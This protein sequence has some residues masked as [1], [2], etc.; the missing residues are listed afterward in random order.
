M[1]VCLPAENEGESDGVDP[2]Q[3]TMEQVTLG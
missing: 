3:V 2:G 1:C